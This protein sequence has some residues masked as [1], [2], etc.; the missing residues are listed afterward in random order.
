MKDLARFRE[1]VRAQRRG[2]GRTQ[3]ALARVIGLHPDVLSHRLNGHGGVALTPDDVARIVTTLVECGALTTRRGARVLLDL[4]DAPRAIPST[5]WDSFPLATL[6]PD[7]PASGIDSVSPLTPASSLPEFKPLPLVA[8]AAQPRVAPLPLPTPLTPLTGRAAECGAVHDALKASR[9]VTLTGVGGTGKTRL[10]LQVAQEVASHFRSG[11]AFVDLASIHD[12]AL[13]SMARA[14]RLAEQSVASTEEH[15]IEALH[16]AHL[17]MV[18]DNLEHLAEE[19]PLLEHLGDLGEQSLLEVTPGLAPHFRFLETVREYAQARLAESR[20]E[21]GPGIWASTSRWRA[22]FAP[23]WLDRI[24]RRGWTDWRKRISM[25]APP[26]SGRGPRR[27]R[28][29]RGW[30]RVSNWRR[31][32]LP[33]RVIA[34]ISS[35]GACTSIA[36]WPSTIVGRR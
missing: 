2:V 23:P 4:A 19:A 1:A 20:S 22:R 7:E 3:A 24:E 10:A 36:C 27:R 30:T 8:A 28:K 5:A 15:L 35:K 17:L 31:R 32:S 21:S 25:F 6:E 29:G 18:V 11:A 14:L 9:L 26:S 33:S 12:P 16:S 34:G 13:L